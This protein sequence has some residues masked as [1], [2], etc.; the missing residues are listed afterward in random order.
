MV[1]GGEVDA[2]DVRAAAAIIE[3]CLLHHA[4]EAAAAFHQLACEID[5][6]AAI[7]LAES[8]DD[9]GGSDFR[10]GIHDVLQ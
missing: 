2:V 3:I 7:V 9:G 6:R 4:A 5:Q 8:I 10:F 1:A